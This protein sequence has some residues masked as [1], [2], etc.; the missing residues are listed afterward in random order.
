M[1][2]P[3][4]RFVSWKKLKVVGADVVSI[5]YRWGG[6]ETMKKSNDNDRQKFLLSTAEAVLRLFL[7]RQVPRKC[8]FLLSTAEAVLRRIDHNLKKLFHFYFYC[9]PLRRYWDKALPM[10]S[11]FS[12][13]F[14][15]FY[16]LP[17][18]RY[19]DIVI[20]NEWIIWSSFLLSTAEAVLRHLWRVVIELFRSHFYCLPLR[21]YWDAVV[22][23]TLLNAVDVF[24]LSTADAVLRPI[25]SHPRHVRQF[26]SIVYRWGGIETPFLQ[27]QI[28]NDEFISIVYRWGGIE[29]KFSVL[30][31]PLDWNISIVY[32]W[33]GIETSSVKNLFALCPF[34]LSTAEAVLRRVRI[35]LLIWAA[36]S[37][38]YRW[39]GIEPF[40]FFIC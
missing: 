1:P 19:W 2:Y 26:I 3:N 12:T 9:L 15:Y 11:Q 20:S 35:G 24:L 18:R 16:C 13:S 25:D 38:V 8:G 17:L 33:G 5:V 29:T 10:A 7:N 14:L 22:T 23:I 21:R 36:I 40:H 31:N 30:V 34:L 32:R 27:F 37:I 4:V 6:I 39:G 28:T